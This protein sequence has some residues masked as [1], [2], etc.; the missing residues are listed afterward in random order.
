MRQIFPDKYLAKH[1]KSLVWISTKGAFLNYRQ[2]ARSLLVIQRGLTGNRD[3]VGKN[4]METEES[5]RAYLLYY[6]PVSYLQ[7]WYAVKGCSKLLSYVESVNNR[8]LSILDLGSGPGPATVSL[9]DYLSASLVGRKRIEYDI[10]L[11]DSSQRALSV[12]K[13]IVDQKRVE[14]CHVDFQKGGMGFLGDK[15]FDIIIASHSLNELWKKDS[16]RNTQLLSFVNSIAEHL[17]PGGKIIFI[18]PALL[19]TSRNLIELRNS[20]VENGYSVI[21]PCTCGTAQCPA[22]LQENLTCHN[23]IKW[24]PVEPVSNI[25]REAKLDRESVKMT[26]FIFEKSQEEQESVS[27][28]ENVYSG[29]IVSDGML[30]KSGRLRYI[31]CD[32]KNR[33]AFS[34]KKD[35]PAATAQGFFKLKRFDMVK[36]RNPEIRE[37]GALGFQPD[38]EIKVVF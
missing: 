26:F 2:T 27:E 35:D 24:T 17:Q 21:A 12:A 7:T 38:T 29:R 9:M 20:M 3:L 4:Y 6:W 15:K 22:I 34:A 5:L 16:G 11:C 28:D 19:L 1:I 23:E 37:G 8:P 30:N 36:I 10:T 13:K 14:T 33:I 32:G 31:L 18:E 25:A